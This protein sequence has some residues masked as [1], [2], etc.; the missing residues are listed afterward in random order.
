MS[1]FEKNWSERADLAASMLSEYR[2]ICDVG[3]GM[4]DL[5]RALKSDVKYFPMDVAM[6]S[7]DTIVCEINNKDFPLEYI[8]KADATSVLGVIEYL[9]EPDWLLTEISKHCP[10]LLVS[11]CTA[12]SAKKYEKRA[13]HGWMNAFTEEQFKSLLVQTNWQISEKKYYAGTQWL[14]LCN[15]SEFK[16]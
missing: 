7:D 5:R 4:Q 12:E 15:R 9:T 10:T 6:R 13:E 3:C 8:V 14:W 16:P 1:L 11:Y 2:S